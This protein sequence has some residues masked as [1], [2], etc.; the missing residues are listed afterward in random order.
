MLKTNETSVRRDNARGLKVAGGKFETREVGNL[1]TTLA[2]T[3]CR[4]ARVVG[5]FA[6]VLRYFTV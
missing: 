5:R 6:T 3:E 4:S 2:G 1:E